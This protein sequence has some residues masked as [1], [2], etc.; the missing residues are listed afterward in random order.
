MVRG[1]GN[2]RLYW[3]MEKPGCLIEEVGK[4]RRRLP[5]KK[6]KE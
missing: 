4:K 2:S 6:K 5:E 3:E 1:E